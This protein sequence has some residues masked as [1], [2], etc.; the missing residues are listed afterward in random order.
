MVIGSDVKKRVGR[1]VPPIKRLLDQRDALAEQVAAQAAE[2]EQ[3]GTLAFPPGHFCSPLPSLEEV[4]SRSAQI[5]HSPD[6]LPEIDPEPDSQMNLVRSLST[7]AK[8]ANFPEHLTDE[9]RYYYRNDWF[10]YGD[11]IVLHAMLRFL[12]PARIVEIGS[13]FSS[14]LIL[15]TNERNLGGRMHCTFIEPHPDRLMTLL[16]ANDQNRADI[17]TTPLQDVAQDVFLGLCA[18]DV[19]FIDSSHV[20]KIGSDVN[21]L[22]FEVLPKLPKGVFV[23]FHDIFY[24]FEYP[25]LWV[26]QGRGWNE[27]YL[28]RAYLQANRGYRIRLWNSFLARFYHLEVARELPQWDHETG[29]SIWLERV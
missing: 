27:A 4:R 28:L 8:E 26:Y 11:A 25:E 9:Y 24:P 13:G 15:D 16:R 12:K 14:A 7:F 2:L 19:L 22:I 21:L 5:F 3:F 10:S 17:I 29:G 6:S 18:K 20:S 1:Y 23:H